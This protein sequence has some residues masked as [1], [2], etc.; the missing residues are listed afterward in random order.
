MHHPSRPAA[1]AVAQHPSDR[2]IAASSD[3]VIVPSVT[4]AGLHSRLAP[5]VPVACLGH[6]V[7][8][9][10]PPRAGEDPPEAPYFLCA[11]RLE[12]IKG[13]QTLLS[14]FRRWSGARLVVAGTGSLE[15][16]LR[17]QAGDLPHVEFVG[18]KTAQSL[19][20]LLRGALAVIAPT[21]GHESFG[22]VPVEALAR[23]V[24]AIV[25][26]FGALGELVRQSD[27][28]I[29]YEREDDLVAELD[30]LAKAPERRAALGETGRRDYLAHWAEAKHMRGYFGLIADRA[31][32]RGL[33][34]LAVAAT[35]ARDGEN[36]AT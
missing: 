34:Q 15:A 2:D 9:P 6:F 25:R 24:P 4:S 10:G 29:G 26:D 3:L 13:V 22:L 32:D 1:A 27:A 18:W 8:D 33:R 19:D 23:G 20:R 7:P 14:A 17:E 11:G 31:E 16:R 21:L 28:I 12:P 30:G 35:A 36:V 5:I